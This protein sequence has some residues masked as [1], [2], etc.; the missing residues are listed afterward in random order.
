M[1]LSIQ[2]LRVRFRMG[3]GA[4]VA[5]AEAVGRGDAGVSFEVPENGTVALVGESGSGKSVT[6]MSILNLL[7]ENAQ[8][9]GTIRFQGRDLLGATLSELQSLR[10]K[11]IA[12]VFQ[13]PMSSLNPVFSVG[14]QL[15]EPL[16]K[17]LGLS[18][19]Q[20]RT[21]A[22]EALR[23]W[24]DE[25]GVP[26][27]GA[28]RETQNYVR[29]TERGLTVFDLPATKVQA[30]LDQW[31]PILDWL[32]PVMNLALRP[33][34]PEPG[35]RAGRVGIARVATGVRAPD[36]A[37]SSVFTAGMIAVVSIFLELV[38]LVLPMINGRLID[39][40]VPRNDTHLLFV[41]LIGLA[42]AV[43]FFFAASLTRSQLLLQLR[44]RFE[45]A[46]IAEFPNLVSLAPKLSRFVEE[47]EFGMGVRHII[48]SLQP[49]V[50]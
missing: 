5:Y 4:N 40:V 15:V 31:Q 12:C 18:G 25:L 36:I 19:S 27:V 22:E 48:E 17:H 8:R 49:A 3:R 9:Q 30:D 45:S 35:E 10:G 6:A 32:Q 21:R 29:C 13:D 42:L 33:G 26:F 16:H 24:S 23:A 14:Q 50:S 41:L 20:A 47:T 2:D 37:R 28:L 1:L 11:E 39:R 44:T 7:P 46:N 34:A 43:V 38:S